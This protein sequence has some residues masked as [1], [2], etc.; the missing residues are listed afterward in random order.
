MVRGLPYGIVQEERAG[1]KVI[2]HGC[3]PQSTWPL[4][5]E[6]GLIC[7]TLAEFDTYL[8]AIKDILL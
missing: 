6:S 4:S 2:P 5:A 8:D 7:L 3:L 1:L